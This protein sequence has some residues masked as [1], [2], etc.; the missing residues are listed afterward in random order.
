MFY[1]ALCFCSFVFFV[2]WG[3]HWQ[4]LGLTSG[5]ALRITPTW[6]S[7]CKVK[8]LSPVLSL[9]TITVYFCSV[10]F[11]RQ[12]IYR[13][14]EQSWKQAGHIS[15]GLHLGHCFSKETRAVFEIQRFMQYSHYPCKN[16]LQVREQCISNSP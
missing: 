16:N 7:M 6:E 2:C 3:I 1:F 11:L 5:S 12:L 14:F 10:S 8:A 15:W 9:C 13:K 4:Y